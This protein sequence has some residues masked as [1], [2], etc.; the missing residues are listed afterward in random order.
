[1]RQ[2]RP[3]GSAQS[4]TKSAGASARSAH[5]A[6]AEPASPPRTMMPAKTRSRAGPV[7][8]GRHKNP[9]AANTTAAPAARRRVSNA[10]PL[11]RTSPR[12]ASGLGA[13]GGGGSFRD[14]P[15]EELCERDHE[16]Q[17]AQR[18]Q[19]NVHDVRLDPSGLQGSQPL[20]A[21]CRPPAGREQNAFERRIV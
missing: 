17:E 13:I 16:E 5:V 19:Q 1:C 4:V 11:R 9:L 2:N 7:G 20:Q 15:P 6:P 12:R 3:H 8:A 10:P 18:R 21:V 14:E